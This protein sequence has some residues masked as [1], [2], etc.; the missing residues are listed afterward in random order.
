MMFAD[1]P[2][3][4]S[5]S[6]NTDKFGLREQYDDEGEFIDIDTFEST[7]RRCNGLLGGSTVFGV[8]ATSDRTTISS[9]LHRPRTP[10]LNLG[11]RG[12]TG[13]QE[14]ILFLLFRQHFPD[15]RNVVLFTGVNNCAL[16]ARP[17][18][19]V[20]PGFGGV[21]YEG[22]LLSP[23]RQQE[24]QGIPRYRLTQLVDRAYR[25]SR[26]V[27]GAARVLLGRRTTTDGY[28]ANFEE[29]LTQIIRFAE[30]DLAT[31][32]QLQS[33]GG[34]KV[35][36]VLQPAINWTERPLTQMEAELFAAD[37]ELFPDTK[38]FASHPVYEEY[39]AKIES[40]C[41]SNGID[42][43]DANLWLNEPRFAREELFTD[44]CH[45]TD[46]GNAI[47]AGL[48]SDRLDWKD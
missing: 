14:L 24:L 35:H 7:G 13:Q 48:L 34:F 38:L 15:I 27:R 20:Y 40:S 33:A 41:D 8:G 46:T 30:N 42:F 5:H 43:H 18:T 44:V 12:A 45:L 17:G 16:A 23:L 1:Q 32:G 11:V 39:R 3:Y 21:F 9:R 37:I 2:G 22:M 47:V 25:G 36:L 28:R 26:L 4:R 29:K 10:C 6:V 31:W 19:K